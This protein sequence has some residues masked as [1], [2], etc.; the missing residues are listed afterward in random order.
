M[1][2]LGLRAL[3]VAAILIV[4]LLCLIPTFTSTSLPGLSNVLPEKI[5]L[6]LD[7]QG[8]IYLALEVEADKAVET[9]GERFVEEIKDALRAKKIAFT[10]VARTGAWDI[11]VVL[12]SG[13]QLNEFNE[14]L[15]S[16]FPRLKP[17]TAETTPEGTKVVLTMDQKEI[18]DLRKMAVDQGL[19][20]IRNRIDQFGVTEP[21][22][23]PEAGD[24]ILVQLPGI[25][26]PQ[27]AVNLIGKTAVLEFKLVAQ[28]VTDQDIRDNK[29]PP[30]VKLYPMRPSDRN[31]QEAKIPLEDK[32][33]LTGQ[34]ITDARVEIGGR[35]FGEVQIALNFDPQ[36]GKLF[37][38]LTS[39][40][41]G[42]RLA[43]VLDGVVY[44]D[45]VIKERIPNGRAVITGSYTDEEAKVLAIALRTGRLPAP[46]KILEERTVGPAL[47][48]DSIKK[49]VLASAIGGLGII[50]F[51]MV[52]YRFSGV[53]AD[54]ALAMNILLI[55]AIMALIGATLTLPGIAG[56]ALTIG[57]A[58]DANV[59][60]Y[61]RI[62]EELRL[63]K[64]PR[65]AI[66]TGYQRATITIMDA[67]VTSA[68]AALVLYGFGTGPVRGFAVTLFFG[69]AANM[70]TAIFVTRI[71]FD[72][73]LSE[74]RVKELSI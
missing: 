51:M 4:G 58:V 23:R 26:N 56:I 2:N 48:A 62:R 37:E 24:R 34:Y 7:L 21:D 1:K 40:N 18:N 35:S 65:A 67:N 3:L 15:K 17:A 38:R 70:F 27:E 49:G 42:R 47:G 20:T 9:A 66:D 32:T 53:I 30:G 13:E 68:I 14:T 33:V 44:S 57:I 52:Y 59:L 39:D 36:G 11:D 16:D 28:N 54:L 41:V 69:L 6:G 71:I 25:K 60:I 73:L 61:E 8:G 29:L 50:L 31:N 74:R 10:K 46:V 43:I 72:Y 22:I 19:E 64:T 45:P 12:P 63:G 5:H 55:L